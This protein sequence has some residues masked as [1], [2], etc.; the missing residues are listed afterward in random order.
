MKGKKIKYN[1][2]LLEI[3][4]S[5]NFSIMK[6]ANVINMFNRD[7]SICIIEE[8]DSSVINYT[9]SAN[10]GDFKKGKKIRNN[11]SNSIINQSISINDKYLFSCVNFISKNIRKV[12]V[13][14]SY[15]TFKKKIN[16]MNK[17]K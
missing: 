9:D 15:N 3:K 6:K 10:S 16:M 17:N 12:I 5:D 14:N 7:K 13:K 2:N 8:E 11:L 4:N 1:E